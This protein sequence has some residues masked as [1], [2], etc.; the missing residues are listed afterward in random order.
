MDNATK[1]GI[2]AA[3]T[4]SK[5]VAQKTSEATGDLIQNKIANKVSSVGKTKSK[6]IKDE[7]NKRQEIYIL[8][9]KRQQMI[10]KLTLFQTQY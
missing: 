4:P 5:R 3:K 6:E 9:E 8:A 7:T 10:D 2:N 1:T